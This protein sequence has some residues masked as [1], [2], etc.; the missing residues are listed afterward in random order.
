MSTL[1][2][3]IHT[4]WGLFASCLLATLFTF[5]AA[6]AQPSGARGDDF[7][8]RVI[9]NDTLIDISSRFTGT[10][11]NWPTLQS[12]NNVADPSALQIGRELRIPFALIP[13]VDAEAEVTHIIGRVL[14]NKM[15]AR[16]HDSLREG[17]LVE[18]REHSFATIEL[19]DGFISALPPETAV[20]IQRLK[21]FQGTG[22][23][24]AIL[25]LDTGDLESSVDPHGQGVGRFEVRTP[26]SITG[27]R[28]TRL[29]VRADDQ[30]ARTE[31]LSGMAQL[32]TGAADGPR[33]GA[34]QGT[35]VTQDGTIL[36]A[37]ALL[38]APV[39]L[40]AT[41][42]PGRRSIDFEPVPGAVAYQVRVAADEAGTQPVWSDTITAPPV[43]YHT[44]GGGVWFVLVRAI[45][46]VGLMSDDARI[47]VKGGGVL[48][49]GAGTDV[50][51]AFGLPVSLTD[52]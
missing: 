28:G 48:I 2:S 20:R 10:S 29:R 25:K 47:E 27:V 46:D 4:V 26:V 16:V 45:D 22:I 19:P 49:S 51:T 32:G 44:P 18:T 12:L 24:D 1:H 8:Y 36:A 14:I 13:E 17:D 11:D 52:Y 5:P 34:L 6:Q 50:M 35:A 31:V 38:P 42:H 39:L 21:T 23:V 40:P 15:P 41:E 3:R 9:Q 33:L 43:N 7:I 37:R 30:G